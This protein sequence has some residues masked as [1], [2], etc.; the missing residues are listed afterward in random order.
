MYYSADKGLWLTD[1][2][3]DAANAEGA[4]TFY[5]EIGLSENVLYV[6]L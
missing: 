6:A 4:L 2:S 3:L 5:F 1:L